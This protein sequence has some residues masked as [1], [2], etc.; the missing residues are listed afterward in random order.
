MHLTALLLRPV[1]EE[2]GEYDVVV[3]LQGSLREVESG[4]LWDGV[5]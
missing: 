2:A 3:H 1:M 5:D 4:Y